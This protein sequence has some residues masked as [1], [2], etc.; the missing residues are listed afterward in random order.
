[1]AAA[2]RLR[3][4]V[5]AH[6]DLCCVVFSESCEPPTMLRRPIRTPSS[7]QVVATPSH[8]N[9]ARY[10]IADRVSLNGRFAAFSNVLRNEGF[11]RRH[12]S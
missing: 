12:V 3:E 2:T 1:M 10:C 7:L 11:P 9:N 6:V 8:K 4:G 5:L